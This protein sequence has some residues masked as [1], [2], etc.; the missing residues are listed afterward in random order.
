MYIYIE[1]DSLKIKL[2]EFTENNSP[3][4]DSSFFFQEFSIIIQ[5]WGKKSNMKWN[6]KLKIIYSNQSFFLILF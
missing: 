1:F 3:N 5:I 6:N 2:N 4:F